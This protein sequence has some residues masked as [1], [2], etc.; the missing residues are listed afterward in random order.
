MTPLT[1]G[2]RLPEILLPPRNGVL[3]TL[4]E[5]YCGRPLLIIAAPTLQDLAPLGSLAGEVEL[6]ALMPTVPPNIPHLPDDGRLAQLLWGGS[7]ATPIAVLMDPTLR[8]IQRFQPA[9]PDAIRAALRQ[10]GDPLPPVAPITATA[11]V[12]LLPQV[13]DPQLCQD[14]IAAHDADHEE[15]GMI[16]QVQGQLRLIPDPQVKRRQDHRL[17]DPRLLAD[18]TQSLSRRILPAIA[19]AFHYNVTRFEAF[20]IVAY[21][22]A[23]G[24]YFRR[25]RDNT[26][27]D[28]RHRRFALSINLNDN[29]DGGSLVFPEFG[30]MPYRPP[31]GGSLVFS[32]SLLHEAT[33]VTAG[34]RYVVI[35]FLWGDDVKE[36]G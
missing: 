32:G 13:L 4:Y 21:D 25:H 12:L 23:T 19:A 11:P 16:R 5:R 35:S 14:L 36:P 3:Q 7:P 26:T 30:S 29:Y 6:L 34:R 10:L 2:D 31:A 27:P 24:G 9:T 28:A 20:K 17:M 15:S 33:D 8:L 18:L 1:P 22:A